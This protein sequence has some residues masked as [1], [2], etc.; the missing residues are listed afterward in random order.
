[1]HNNLVIILNFR[2]K[3][4]SVWPQSRTRQMSLSLSLMIQCGHNKLTVKKKNT[5][6]AIFSYVLCFGTSIILNIFFNKLFFFSNVKLHLSYKCRVLFAKNCS[7]YNYTREKKPSSLSFVLVILFVL[8]I[9]IPLEISGIF[10]FNNDNINAGKR[11]DNF[12]STHTRYSI[13]EK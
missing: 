2:S 10:F 9:T 5:S 6:P 13:F 12:L 1:M 4:K 11:N 8:L 7:C 3:T